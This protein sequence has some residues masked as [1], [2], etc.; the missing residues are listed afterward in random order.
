[1]M[2]QRY[3]RCFDGTVHYQARSAAVRVSAS[4]LPNG[5]RRP[6]GRSTINLSG[7]NGFFLCFF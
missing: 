2:H 6:D 4:L 5:A 1:M 3:C 7:V